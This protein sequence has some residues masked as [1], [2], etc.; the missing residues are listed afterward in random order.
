MECQGGCGKNDD[1]VQ[2][3]RQRT[4]Y[5]DDKE[6]FKAL[7]PECQKNEDEYWDE[8]WKDYYANCM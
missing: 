6:N 8:M 4:Q 2:R 7:C 3:R 5:V 1:T